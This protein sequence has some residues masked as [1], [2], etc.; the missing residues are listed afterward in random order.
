M[1]FA[2]YQKYKPF[3][4]FLEESHFR[5]S[6]KN[7]YLTLDKNFYKTYKS[8]F[9]EFVSYAKK[10][11]LNRDEAFSSKVKI[12]YLKYDLIN[13][14]PFLEEGKEVLVF[15]HWDF[16][17]MLWEFESFNIDYG[18]I[19]GDIVL[20]YEIEVY[21]DE[22]DEFLEVSNKYLLKKPF[23]VDRLGENEVLFFK[24]I[25]TFLDKIS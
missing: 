18:L 25:V 3:I 22:E 7:F 5:I 13:K 2:L 10:Y 9:K 24:A 17:K 16:D 4:S 11:R 12:K 19:S 15:L 1:D 20:G 21:L 14:K 23:L 6:N 8:F